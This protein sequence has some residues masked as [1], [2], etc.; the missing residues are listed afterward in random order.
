MEKA[1]E[2]AEGSQL[3]EVLGCGLCLANGQPKAIVFE[4]ETKLL[5]NRDKI[6]ID[7]K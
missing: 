3:P 2:E 4:Q 5:T 7:L 1:Q 6:V